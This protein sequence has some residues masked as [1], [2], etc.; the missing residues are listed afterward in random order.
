MI[1]R[2]RILVEGIVQ[3][4][5]FRPAVF[6]LAEKMELGG[7]I[8]NSTKGVEIEI[9]GVEE[10][11]AEFIAVLPKKIP[12]RAR[13]LKLFS[14]EIE[15]IKDS[16]TFGIK[17]SKS[18]GESRVLVSPDLPTCDDCLKEI[19]Y[20]ANRRFL[21]PFTNC[22][23]CGPRFTIIEDIPYDRSQ[24][25]MRYFKMCSDCQREY[26]NPVDRRFHA[27]PNACSKC[28]PKLQLFNAGGDV[29][30]DKNV[31]ERAAA[32]IIMGKII[33]IKG[34]GGYHLVCD[35]TNEQ[36]VEELR[37]RKIREDKPFA[38]MVLNEAMAKRVCDLSEAELELL[39]SLERSIVIAKKKVNNGV[40]YLVAPK[41]PNIGIIL[42]YTPLHHIL[43]WYAQRPLVMTS[44]NL[45]D[46]PIC[47]ENQEAIERLKN[48][49]DYF[50]THNRPI[51]VRCDDS[52]V[53]IFGEQQRLIRRSRGY[54]PFPILL[55]APVE[56]TI[57]G[58]GALLKNTFC[59]ADGD[60]A[61]LSHHIGDLENS[62]TLKSFEEGI[63]HFEKIFHL[64]PEIIAYD[65]HPD[66]LSTKWA[67]A[68]K[69]PKIGIQHHHA[70]IVGVMA[71]YGLEESVIGVAFDGTGYGTD[72]KIWGGE[73]LITDLKNFQ[74]T[75]HLNYVKMPS[76]EKAIKEPWRMAL[77]YLYKVYGDKMWDLEIDFVK[78][79]DRNAARILI[80]AM[81]QNFN[82]PETSSVGRLFDAVS[83]LLGIC[84][85]ANY[86]GQ[87][88]IELEYA[89]AKT[90]SP[91]KSKSYAFFTFDENGQIITG[92]TA[93]LKDII[94]DIVDGVSKEIIAY[95]FH[96]TITEIIKINCLL[97]RQ[98]SGIKKIVL[99]GGVFQNNL[100][101]GLLTPELK[102]E[103]FEIFLPSKV[104]VNDA[105]ISLGQV[106]I[107]NKLLEEK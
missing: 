103:G 48:V 6:N 106:V 81:N 58:V 24:T 74:R 43:L 107:A 31:L 54:A 82:S 52:V 72:G 86:E 62:Q 29:V 92:I 33:A 17:K 22:T 97:I 30:D 71:E 76:G 46:E 21:Y 102:Q 39:N 65:L 25:S 66:Y 51:Y 68:Q 44:A 83:A 89:A 49:A 23:N 55:K 61:F 85:K 45:S 69:L 57:L 13:I 12:S 47:Y 8:L 37:R 96:K 34:L 15:I 93:I 56:K 11:C 59:I 80:M 2:F 64:R 100:L 88:A 28:G 70:H 77:S 16:E 19:F 1:K 14:K 90:Q 79:I 3:G 41:N 78:N 4:V 10:K 7:F 104:P 18:G 38:L 20:P 98:N 75:G 26:D 87:A 95:R 42:P 36:A 67:E 60:R 27:Q 105:G 73:F 91:E 63:K 99:G 53:K 50:L 40:A 94:K 32:F 35:A 84:Q 101:L 5:G 9:Q